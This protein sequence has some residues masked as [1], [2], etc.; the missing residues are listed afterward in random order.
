M[1]ISSLASLDKEIR[2]KTKL[3]V[4]HAV[5][6]YIYNYAVHKDNFKEIEGLAK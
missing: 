4:S 5:D 3:D 1:T 6:Q 2:E